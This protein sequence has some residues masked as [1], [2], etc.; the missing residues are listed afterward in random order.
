MFYYPVSQHEIVS[1]DRIDRVHE[2]KARGGDAGIALVFN[3]SKK[4]PG[5]F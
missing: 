5:M 4:S 1:L 3:T 2:K